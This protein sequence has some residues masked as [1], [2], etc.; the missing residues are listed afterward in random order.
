MNSDLLVKR[1]IPIILIAGAAILVWLAA[2]VVTPYM[3]SHRPGPQNPSFAWFLFYQSL[4][5]VLIAVVLL[6]LVGAF[7][8]WRK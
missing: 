1:L 5:V 6:S 4:P 3:L 8:L 7:V 2:A